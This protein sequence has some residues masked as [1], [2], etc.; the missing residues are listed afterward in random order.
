MSGQRDIFS[1]LSK[2]KKADKDVKVKEK[3]TEKKESPVKADTTNKSKSRSPSPSRKKQKV[4][5][6]EVEVV[7]P[8]ELKENDKKPTKVEEELIEEDSDEEQIKASSRRNKSSSEPKSEPEST[9]KQDENSDKDELEYDSST[10]QK[11]HDDI[12]KLSKLEPTKL[13]TKLAE[14]KPIPYAAVVEI[15]EKIESTTK[16]LEIIKYTSDFFLKVLQTNP[17]DL[18]PITYLFINRLGPDYEGLELGLGETIL[19]KTISESTGKN[20]QHVKAKYREIGDLGT[21]AL[22]ARSVQPTMFKPKPLTVDTVFDNL[23]QISKASG[24]DSQTKKI[25]IIKRML[26]A[27]QGLEA[28]FLIRSLESKLR[29]GL[30]EK[31]VLISL[32]KALATFEQ[33]NQGKK[34]ERISP[35]LFI[36]AEEAIRDAFCQVPNYEVLINTAI[37]HGVLKLGDH[38]TLKPGIPLKPMLAKPTKSVGE[39]LDRFNGEE[40][41]CEYKY[42]GER[43]QVHLLNNGEVKVYS[44]NSEDMSQRYPDIID[45][46]KGFLKPDQDTK[47]LIL[48]C[49]AVAWDRVDEKILPFQ[50]LST[51]KRKDVSTEDIKVQVCLFAFDMLCYNDEPLISKPLRERRNQLYKVLN[52]IPG[53]FQFATSK[54]TSDVDELQT[55]LDESVKSACEGLMVKTLDSDPYRPSQRSNSWLKLKKD[56]L[57]GVGDSLDLVVIGAYYGRGKRTGTYGGFLLAS[58]NQ[59]SGEYETC[60]KI[61]TGFSD[62]MLKTLYEKLSKT[63]I[64]DPKSEF[65]FDSSAEPDVWFEPSTLFE[66]LTAD[67]SLSP[68]YKAGAEVFGRGVSLRFPRFLRIR[69][70]KSPEDATSSDQVVEFYERQSAQQ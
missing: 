49:E 30:A 42:D 32:A 15:F 21:V 27:S 16:R 2:Q 24:K 44:R 70:D 23:K 65:T 52:P 35:D 20:T 37:E 5:K 19:I 57:E 6:S 53:K 55:F 63:E 14:K 39:V 10:E 51:R 68:V 25:N 12:Q 22:Q 11:D 62:E 33:L 43:A 38:C 31:T 8:V 29:I 67:L 26:T 60:C 59:D 13:E 4:E 61:G 18:I 48:D 50:V 3:P 9:T 46:V 64:E 56:Y 28:K 7:K 1:M 17:N 54:I 36:K 66:V 58:Y 45:S 34:Q 47:S 69:D 41:T 40:F